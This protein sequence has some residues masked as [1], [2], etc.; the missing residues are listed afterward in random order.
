MA[1]TDS[2][3][4]E[5]DKKLSSAST[6]LL[7]IA[8]S[9]LSIEK[10]KIDG[11]SRRIVLR[12]IRNVIDKGED[13]EWDL[14]QTLTGLEELL[15]VPLEEQSESEE[16]EGGEKKI[17]KAVK[18]DKIR[19]GKVESG[20]LMDSVKNSEKLKGKDQGNS[21]DLSDLFRNST[22]CKEFKVNGV[23]GTIDQIN[24]LSYISLI[25]QIKE[26]SRMGFSD[27]EI[28]AGTI[29]AIPSGLERIFRDQVKCMSDLSSGY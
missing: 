6:E 20:K 3:Y 10:S 18:A 22:F 16:N 15:T 21:A 26:G 4:L 29:K 2:L 27:E 9:K 17:K 11:K 12:D 25:R 14:T 1:E 23:I 8:A 5:V 13:E 28:I 19:I 7:I 24:K